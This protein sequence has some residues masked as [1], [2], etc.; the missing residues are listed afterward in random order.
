MAGGNKGKRSAVGKA[1]SGLG[2]DGK[3]G[4][5]SKG[6]DKAKSRNNPP[7][8][9]R[10]RYDRELQEE[11][12]GRAKD[13]EESNGLD[14]SSRSRVGR[15]KP[16][17]MDRIERWEDLGEDS[18]DEFHA[19]SDKVLLD[20]SVS[21]ARR[22][23]DDDAFDEDDAAEEVFGVDDGVGSDEEAGSDDGEDYLEEETPD[24][25][26][27]GRT[28]EDDSD[29]DESDDPSSANLSALQ[30]S[31][32]G[33]RGVRLPALAATSDGSASEGD[34]N[35]ANPNVAPE[36]W[37]R[38]RSD[39]YGDDLHAALV[40]KR[41]AEKQRMRAGKKGARISAPE[42]EDDSLDPRKL[43]EEEAE[44]I[45]SEQYKRLEAGKFWDAEATLGVE[46]LPATKD[47]A[48]SDNGD[49]TA[50]DVWD[51][52][53]GMGLD[54]SD[55]TAGVRDPNL[56]VT[57]ESLLEDFRVVAEGVHPMIRG[58]RHGADV[59][60]D[61]VADQAAEEEQ[62]EA[63]AIARGIRFLESKYHVSLSYLLHILLYVL[64]CTN[65]ASSVSA[66]RHPCVAVLAKL[67]TLNESLETVA[68]EQEDDDL[69]IN[70]ETKRER[71]ARR[72]RE[73]EREKLRKEGLAFVVSRL[74]EDGTMGK[75]E[76][77]QLRAD[78]RQ[79]RIYQDADVSDAHDEPVDSISAGSSNI[80]VD[81]SESA[82]KLSK[83]AKT[84]S[85]NSKALLSNGSNDSDPPNPIAMPT[86]IP[87]APL[88]TS[89]KQ[90]S[91]AEKLERETLEAERGEKRKSLRFHVGRVAQSIEHHKKRAKFQGDADIPYRTGFANA[92]KSIGTE[93]PTDSDLQPQLSK[94]GVS[95]ATKDESFDLDFESLFK[96]AGDT[97]DDGEWTIN[98]GDGRRRI[99][100]KRKVAEP[101]E[102][103][104]EGE[105]DPL[106]YYESVKRRK[107]EKK[108]RGREDEMYG[109]EMELDDGFSGRRAPNSKILTNRGLAPHRPKIQRNP[110]L[111]KR[112]Q[113]ERKVTKLS[114]FK[115]VVGRVANVVAALHSGGGSAK[116]QIISP[117]DFGI[118][119][120]L[121]V[122]SADY[123]D[124]LKHAHHEWTEYVGGDPA[125]GVTP[126]VWAT[127]HIA[128]IAAKAPPSPIT[129]PTLPRS[130]KEGLARARM[131]WLDIAAGYCFLN[132][133]A[134][135]AQYLIQR[136]DAR[137]AILDVDYHHGNGTQSIFY[138]RSNPLFASIHAKW[139]FPHY[140]GHEEEKGVGDGQGF[141]VNVAVAREDCIGDG[142]EQ[143]YLA[144]L[145][146]IITDHIITYRP[147]FLLVSLGV[148]VFQLDP[149]G[150]LG[151]TTR[152]FRQVGAT[153]RAGVRQVEALLSRRVPTLFVLEG[154]YAVGD[155]GSNV[156]EVINGY[157]AG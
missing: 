130:V 91:H 129:N 19:S 126:D 80:D 65:S 27:D 66:T 2:D 44:R 78:Q 25:R 113:F 52:D 7:P 74:L 140:S 132:N 117:T 81:K 32:L 28:T 120:L 73:K 102:R 17:T 51:G 103:R 21:R 88:R 150:G 122:H 75:K 84:K 38:R 45:R 149:V 110:R 89:R 61:I 71:K 16:G 42:L 57:L 145:T 154:G 105:E 30:L 12:E 143:H 37:G 119:P 15:K 43:E 109:E 111:K 127:R 53:D 95:P 139:D 46:S 98:T 94:K 22:G 67:R 35:G 83:P 125:R 155:M 20:A 137:V 39:Y 148:D 36:S 123:I 79:S 33:L 138:D 99:T 4:N 96:G 100:K 9:R 136:H 157:D 106:E 141:T 50:V 5:K 142:G 107:Q 40:A 92:P 77:E 118:S 153:I 59:L 34:D 116:F 124:Y 82:P 112:K 49:E 41:E 26:E 85:N 87:F 29:A 69:P 70:G 86:N 63:T 72:R 134:I 133:V 62:A 47:D 93:N 121:A 68:G 97:E 14:S 11:D 13:F 8:I 101:S 147:T 3:L 108:D 104:Q 114:S 151:I 76:R 58:V 115:R 1:G 54:G 18:E 56:L 60:G 64:L 31:R 144:L 48:A 131:G 146:A 55:G 90:E 135:A 24:G 128:G 152:G 10:D 6:K 156:V 23:A